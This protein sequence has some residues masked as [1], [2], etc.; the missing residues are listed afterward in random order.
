MRDLHKVRSTAFAFAVWSVNEISVLQAGG[1]NLRPE[2]DDRF[3][4]KVV[5]IVDAS[6]FFG[7]SLAGS[8]VS[9]FRATTFVF[10][11]NTAENDPPGLA[12]VVMPPKLFAWVE[13]NL[14]RE[15][16]FSRWERALSQWCDGQCPC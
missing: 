2:E 1:V 6:S 5:H 15:D 8:E 16:G 11:E 4:A 7:E 3:R 14:Y 10:R 12:G 13:R 9:Q